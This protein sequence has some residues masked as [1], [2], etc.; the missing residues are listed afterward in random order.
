M[1]WDANIK[2]SND[3]VL[4]LLRQ[5]RVEEARLAAACTRRARIVL[6]QCIAALALGGLLVKVLAS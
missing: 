3:E 2:R 5:I 4:S 1:D 6:I